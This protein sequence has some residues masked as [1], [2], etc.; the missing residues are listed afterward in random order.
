MSVLNMKLTWLQGVAVV[1]MLYGIPW[2]YMVTL[3]T[4]GQAS[5][6]SKF[7][8]PQRNMLVGYAGGSV[9]AIA[10]FLG[11]FTGWLLLRRHNGWRWAL[12][13]VFGALS[14]G[15]LLAYIGLY[16][17]NVGFPFVRP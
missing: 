14:V 9:T 5:L 1:V 4:S 2:A 3:M 11:V 16:F 15:I 7:G 12:V 17:V 6:A 13:G 10:P 8:P